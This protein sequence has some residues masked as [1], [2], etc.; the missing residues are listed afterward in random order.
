MCIW[1]FPT[2]SWNQISKIHQQLYA[3][4]YNVK[5]P[6]L[7]LKIHQKWSF[8]FFKLKFGYACLG[9]YKDAMIIMLIKN[10]QS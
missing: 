2:Y 5:P 7:T 3:I 8:N 9:L 1:K 4:K 10:Y 6:K